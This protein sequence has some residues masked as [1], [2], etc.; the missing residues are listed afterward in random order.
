MMD[1][2]TS[3]NM[4]KRNGDSTITLNTGE[5]P[6]VATVDFNVDYI[7]SKKNRRLPKGNGI[8]IFSWTDDNFKIIYPEHIK[9]IQPLSDVLNNVRD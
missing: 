8:L 3:L 1:K 5:V 6:I 9:N 4:L 7:K 2:Y